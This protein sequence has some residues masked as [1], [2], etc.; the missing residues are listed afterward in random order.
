[1]KIQISPGVFSAALAVA[2]SAVKAK[3]THPVLDHVLLE[4]A[5]DRLTI[6]GTD[7]ESR[8]WH[9]VSCTVEEPGAVT[10]PPRALADFLEAIIPTEPVRLA[11]DDR[12]KAELVSG[13][14][15]IRVAGLD[16]EQFPARQDFSDPAFDYTMAAGD[17]SALI[18]STAF[19]ATRDES[20]P[21]L[22]GVL[23]QTGSG[24]L[25]CVATDGYRLALREVHADGVPD[26]D[27]IAHAKMLLKL[28]GH[29][30]KAT[31][32]RLVVDANRSALLVDTEQG[33]WAV[34][35]CDGQFPDFNRII[36]REA[37]IA[38]T[39][40][41]DDLLRASRL[42]RGVTDESTD[43][44]G[45]RVSTQIARLTVREDA[46]DV[47]AIS[48][49]GDQEA[50]VTLEAERERG[51]DLQIGFNGGYFRDAIE[52][53]GAE[54]ITLEMTQPDAP[55]IVRAAG[56]RSGHLNVLMPMH[57]ARPAS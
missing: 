46:I 4:A 29:L 51:D 55:S 22:A 24:K 52:S 41:R 49:G 14:T 43:S 6:S 44:S 54:R 12:H 45:R 2:Q 8:A 50:D 53:V 27:V 25:R 47:R 3:S 7:L 23:F 28:V 11:A 35:L 38:V 17:L 16:A 42:I 1:M 9:S 15:R 18:R 19:A 32:A 34:R 10:L 21:V 36:P 56:E 37:P 31:S 39:V 20:R 26:L 40:L 48:T 5:D 57:I 30:D 33:C 13:R